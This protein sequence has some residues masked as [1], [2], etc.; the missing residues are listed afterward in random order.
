V[1]KPRVA[2]I[3]SAAINY[4]RSGR[5]AEAESLYR[6]ALVI[7]SKNADALHF[8]GIIAFQVG[9]H[10]DAVKLITKAIGQNRRS[11]SFHCNL[12]NV[13]LAQGKLAEAATCYE[14]A[15]ALKADYADAHYNLGN[16]YL[17]QGKA[18]KAEA[19]F[20]QAIRHKPDMIE[21]HNNLGDALQSQEKFAEAVESYRQ[22]LAIRPD[23]VETLY[24][25]GI[26]LL[27]TGASEDSAAAFRKALGHKP[28]LAEA[29][30]NL[31]N[32]LLTQGKLA[33]AILSFGQA[34]IHKPDLADAH[35]NLGNALLD[36]G[37]TREAQEAYEQALIHKP[38]LA[39]AHGN[40][41]GILREQGRLDEAL[42]AYRQAIFVKPDFVE[43]H[44]N[45]GDILLTQGKPGEALAS[46]Q[47]ALT[48]E[49]NY[50][51]AFSNLGNAFLKQ[52]RFDEAAA[53]QT[54]A[55]TLKPHFAE[56]HNNLG[57]VLAA[58][59][60]QQEAV[61]S[62]ERALNVDPKFAEAYGNL[63]NAF[64]EQGRLEEAQASY[65]SALALKPN[66]VHAQ[67]N[68]LMS[69]YYTPGCSAAAILDQARRF[70]KDAPRFSTSFDNDPDPHRRLRIGY[71]SGD[72]RFHPVGYFLAPVLGNHDRTKVE[73][74]CY[75]N[76]SQT[77]DMTE[78][79]RSAA[80]HWRT[81]VG[82]PD[83][84]AARMIADDGIDILVDLAGHTALNRL[85]VFARKPAPVQVSWLGYWGTTGLAAMD[86]LVSDAV[87]T[88]VDED[89]FYSEQVVRLP[90]SRFCYAPPD[91]APILAPEPPMRRGKPVTF[92]SFNNLA[93]LG[94]DV[95]RLWA[96]VLLAVPDARLL[97]KWGTLSDDGVRQ[98]LTSAF[99]AAG[100]APDR[101]ILRGK[102]PHAAMLAEYDD[103]DIALDPFPF[104][105]GLT[106]CE[107][108]W[109]GVPVVTL[110][111]AGAPSRQTLGFLSVLGLTEWAAASP[112]D[113]VR[114]GAALAA[115][116]ERLA[117]L[118]GTLRR[119]MAAS[120]LCDGAAFTRNLETAYRD[121]WRRWCKDNPKAGRA[122]R[123][124][125][126]LTTEIT[127]DTK[128]TE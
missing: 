2:D 120:A 85:A 113:Y 14:R 111:H 83:H 41:G 52:G 24:N 25:L 45:L 91:D 125:K 16:V 27:K 119:R 42:A 22:A 117:Q 82:M 19:S 65:K 29:H 51:E 38:D 96:D 69:L 28:D 49:P 55:L 36:Q 127:K 104:C 71:V 109:M 88:P 37:K 79:L 110:P 122:R 5:L 108:L 80:D 32:V 58:Q 93:K 101:L 68:L 9:Q 4:H 3:V 35:Y 107:A 112:A 47:R 62:F 72:F 11:P 89:G 44:N 114:I 43:A 116:G 1:N 18:G 98:R 8:L 105:G 12:G 84:Q 77:D 87:T 67:S 66:D 46:F 99:E 63:G 57:N 60:K 75:A 34:L 126:V 20:R 59:G 53:A 74:F 81:I 7:D 102:S 48:F 94:P 97:L 100:L 50:A 30:C 39:E 17:A 13:Y 95:I 64:R 128:P 21:A 33:E 123:T 15:L 106:S 31:G 54:R 40:L 10:D 78:R 73:I 61:A 121:M 23:L 76:S 103:V 6:Q 92:G 56:A 86:Y 118:R 70:A 26:A 90:L 115:D 124:V